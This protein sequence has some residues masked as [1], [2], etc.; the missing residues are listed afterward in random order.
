MY[1]IHCIFIPAAVKN[2]VINIFL[3]ESLELLDIYIGWMDVCMD[4]SMYEYRERWREG[5]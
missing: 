4:L 1:I 3:S 2:N 5:E